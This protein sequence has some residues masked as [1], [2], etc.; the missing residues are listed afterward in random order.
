MSDKLETFEK[1]GVVP[2]EEEEPEGG[3]T[4][5]EMLKLEKLA[6]RKRALAVARPGPPG[7]TVYPGV[8]NPKGI[9]YKG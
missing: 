3:P 6:H 9:P 2:G 4:T 7:P 8:S 1:F 5:E